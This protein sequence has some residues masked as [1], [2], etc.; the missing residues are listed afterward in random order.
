MSLVSDFRQENGVLSRSFEHTRCGFQIQEIRLLS[1]KW[2]NLAQACRADLSSTG[3]EVESKDS[4]VIDA[5]VPSVSRSD[6][7]C[8]Q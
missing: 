5:L 2:I 3:V 7:C 8:V 4:V 1:G 6:P